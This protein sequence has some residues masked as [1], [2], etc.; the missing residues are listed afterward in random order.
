MGAGAAGVSTAIRLVDRRVPVD[1]LLIDPCVEVGRGRAYGTKD[2]RHL[3]NVRSDKMSA[4]E[5]EPGDFVRWLGDNQDF[6]SRS[7]FGTY[8]ADRL[9]RAISAN[10]QARVRHVRTTVTGIEA[11]ARTLHLADGSTV[12]VDAVVL[13]TGTFAP[14]TSWAPK[15][16][17]DRFVADPWAPGALDNVPEDGDL[18]LVGTGLTMVDMALS[19]DRPGRTLH[20]VSRHGLLPQVHPTRATPAGPPEGLND[21]TGLRQ[22]RRAIR[23]HVA[24][25]TSAGGTWQSALDDIR[26][27]TAKLWAGM[28]VADRAEFLATD[29]RIWDVHR[30]RMPACTAQRI[31]D[32]RKQGR[33]VIHTGAVTGADNGRVTLS[34]GQELA[35]S[36]VVNCTGPE[37][38]VRRADDPLMAALLATGL[39]RPGPLGLGVDTEPDGRLITRD[40]VKRP[41]WTLGALRRGN[42]WESTAYPE[43]RAQAARIAESVVKPRT[44]R[45]PHDGY[46]L[47]LST[48][49]EAARA[50]R[51]GLRRIL[52]V[53][54]GAEDTIAQ[55]VDTDPGFAVG[56]AALAILRQERGAKQQARESL[57]TAREA[58]LNRGTER[59][60]DFVAAVDD[61]FAAPPEKA[62]ATLLRHIQR[63]P[64]DALAVSIAVPTIAFGGVVAGQDG[65]RIIE[66]LH[67]AYGDDWWYLGQLAFVRQDQQRWLE[68]A[69]LAG[70]ALAE[71]PCSGHAVHANT[72][73]YYETG[74]HRAGLA[75]L[76]GW[77][78]TWGPKARHRAHFSWHA[79]LHE[80]ALG[81]NNAVRRRYA[82]QLAPPM[83][84]GAR[85]LVDSAAMLW[86]CSVTGAWQ[87]PLPAREVLDVAPTEWLD[88]PATAFAAL[89][90][91]LALASAGECSG[92]HRMAAYASTHHSGT[93][94]DMVA[95][96]CTGLAAVLE[97]RWETAVTGLSAVLPRVR[98]FGASQAQCE[99]VEDTFLHV[100]MC[101]GHND[102]AAR[103]LTARLDRRESVLDAQRLAKA[104]SQNDN[105]EEMVAR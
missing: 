52:C 90:G 63:W 15:A 8:L 83:V 41:L 76:D 81:D 9:D 34:T 84:T 33:L 25:R 97:G 36:A 70:R 82:D 101:A 59:E 87:E 5:S 68:A 78:D 11:D 20:A 66:D 40:G 13:A 24:T 48:T 73:V 60:R 74:E 38:D 95:P 29:R 92:L 31:D 45:R 102:Q 53:Q 75:W 57:E 98:E 93:F 35:V 32:M 54:D 69:A 62:T 49:A 64:R 56:H 16:L 65:W 12:D 44:R 100:L 71:Q 88:R 22:I 43:I 85:A 50:Y 46:G 6:A 7:D 10:Q 79:G 21:L 37:E 2:R 77:L 42:L 80:L 26:P 47:P 91:A 61:L 104:L 17:G 72:H 51:T 19:F 18:L 27:L 30:H 96:L 103:L 4:D 89:H 28:S 94:V 39:V 3:L 55:A 1:V 23:R 105:T 14:A 67:P 99:V 58:V 86:R